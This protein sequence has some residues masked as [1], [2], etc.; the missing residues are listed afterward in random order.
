MA[1]KAL[2]IDAIAKTLLKQIFRTL[3]SGFVFLPLICDI[4]SERWVF[5]MI[6]AIMNLF[7]CYPICIALA[8]GLF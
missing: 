4:V 6:S 2:V 8:N 5:V 1:R 7:L 3:S